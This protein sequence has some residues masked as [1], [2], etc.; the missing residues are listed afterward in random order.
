[1]VFT[2]HFSAIIV[3]AILGSL[4]LV[5]LF[6]KFTNRLYHPQLPPLLI[7]FGII[8]LIQWI[9]YSNLFHS[10]IGIIKAY[11]SAFQNVSASIVTYSVYNTIPLTTILINS[12]GSALLLVFALVGFIVFC[13]K[14]EISFHFIIAMAVTLS[15]LLG[16]GI[17]LVQLGLLPDRLYPYL[18]VFGLVFLAA[19]GVVYCLRKIKSNAKKI[20]SI[21]FIFLLLSFFSI[22]STIAGFE[23]SLF[24]D[25]NLAYFKLFSA[26]QERYFQ[27][28]QENVT[29]MNI[30]MQEIPLTPSGLIN[31]S[32]IMP[33]SIVSFDQLYL[34]T[35]FV[36]E[37]GYHMGYYQFIKLKPDEINK[38]DVYGKIYSNG[39]M[40]AYK[41]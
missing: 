27:Q 39:I 14:K 1:M 33:N 15:V 24:V 32:Q 17:V 6:H 23:T 26:P 9:Y 31:Q 40:N 36:R 38:M 21:F 8:L 2:H 13:K 5:E 37:I 12:I 4:I 18:Q 29:D 7:I 20:V 10:F 3:L 34:R 28:W 22:A 25:E 35:G 41:I 16:G 11:T 30:S 19:G